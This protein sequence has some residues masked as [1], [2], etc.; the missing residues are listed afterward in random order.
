MDDEILT[1]TDLEEISDYLGGTENTDAESNSDNESTKSASQSIYRN[2]LLTNDNQS[3]EIISLQELKNKDFPPEKWIVDHLVPENG[4]TCISGKPKAGKSYWA[5]YLAVCIALGV[6]FMEKFETQQGTVLFITKEDPQR[7][8]KERAGLLT[9]IEETPIHFCSDT[10]LF[11]D[12]DKYIEEIKKIIKEKKVRVVIIDSLRRIFKGEEN[13]SQVISEVQNRFKVLLESCGVTII[14]IHHHGKDTFFKKE[15]GD[16]LRGSSDIL[17]MIDS[18]LILERKDEHTLKITPAALRTD[19]PVKPFLVK[20]PD[21]EKGE[22]EFKFLDFIEEEVEKLDK[23]KDD[24]LNLLQQGSFNQTE[25]IQQLTSTG[26]Y[27]PTTVKNG[28]KELSETK[29][30]DF[31]NQG[32]KKL[33]LIPDR[34]EQEDE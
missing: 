14:F 12:T 20:F 4:I 30:I 21:F 16:K 6:K 5:L 15:G 34:A 27:G 18:L 13:S 32:N 3:L 24:I 1:D 19:K 2:D 17:A 23:A 26:S 8:L 11:L 22:H 29:K 25:I 7:L 33:Y 10:R 31:I 9:S 28:L